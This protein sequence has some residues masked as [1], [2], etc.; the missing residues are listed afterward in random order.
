MSSSGDR[1]ELGKTSNHSQGAPYNWAERLDQGIRSQVEQEKQAK[2]TAEEAKK[3]QEELIKRK[4]LE[5]E[6]KRRGRARLV[7]DRIGV[8]GYLRQI[9]DSLWKTGTIEYLTEAGAYELSIQHLAKISFNTYTQSSG[10]TNYFGYSSSPSPRVESGFTNCKQA[11]T[12]KYLLEED[13]SE[14]IDVRDWC[15]PVDKSSVQEY[16]KGL[17]VES[18]F[19]SSFV[20]FKQVFDT[21]KPYDTAAEQLSEALAKAWEIRRRHGMTP[22]VVAEV[23]DA[24]ANKDYSYSVRHAADLVRYVGYSGRLSHEPEFT[25]SYSSWKKEKE[26]NA[27]TSVIPPPPRKKFLGLI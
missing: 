12:V 20:I 1:P 25:H 8:P 27:K 26:I 17:Y 14:K 21:E 9:R 7:L 22:L 18:V 15:Y 11:I 19:D 3:A 10:G 5:Y 24:E 13:D 2:I 6:T 23:M 4:A 16:F